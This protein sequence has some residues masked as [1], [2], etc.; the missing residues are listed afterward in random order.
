MSFVL[1]WI[2]SQPAVAYKGFADKEQNAMLFC[3][4][5]NIKK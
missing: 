1:F 5:Q 2:K 3:S 4:L